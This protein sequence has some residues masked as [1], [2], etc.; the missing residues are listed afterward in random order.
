MSD[1]VLRMVNEQQTGRN[2][3]EPTVPRSALRFMLTLI[4]GRRLVY[5][6][7]CVLAG[8]LFTVSTIVGPLLVR[9]VIQ[10]IDDGTGSA[11]QLIP[12]VLLLVAMYLLRGLGRY[13]YGYLSHV[14]AYQVLHDLLAQT[15]EHVQTLSHKYL[16]RQRTGTLMARSISD[17]EMVEDFV[18]HGIPELTLAVVGPLVMTVIL[19]FIDPVV[20]LLALLPLPIASFIVYRKAKKIRLFW[21]QVRTGLAELIALVQDN[22]SG[23]TEI[24]LFNLE[25]FQAQRIHERSRRFRDAMVRAMGVS[26]IPSS[27][28]E[29]AGGL[30]FI[31]VAWSGGHR[32]LQGNLSV[33]DFVLFVS[34]ISHIYLPFMK[35]ADMGDSLSRAYVSLER[36]RETL[37]VQ[38]EIQSPEPGFDPSANNPELAWTV[39][40]R[41]VQFAYGAEGNALEGISFCVHPGQTVALVGPTGAGK[42][43]VGRLIPRLYDVEGGQILVAGT[44]VREWELEPLRRHVSFVLQE[45]FL[46]HGTIRENLL[47]GRPDASQNELNEAIRMAHATEF[48]DNMPDGLETLIGERGVRLSG[49]Q[50]QRISI[51]RALL[52]N[53]PILVLD[54]ATSNVD[55]LT[56]LAIQEALQTLIKGRTTLVIAHRLSTIRNAH[57]VLYMEEGRIRESG[58]FDQLVAQGGGFAVMAEAQSLLQTV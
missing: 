39:E 22:L 40:F 26:M 15:Y 9:R 55:V 56:E 41:D 16:N 45:V 3:S 18:A 10:F 57:K 35:I 53:A 6:L 51:A 47:L 19:L 8:G 28:V 21:R 11:G 49:G 5:I 54:E 34:Y 17:V 23:L 7:L 42:T 33:A 24:K 30:G 44:D 48:I 32:A 36:I 43:T 13:L 38:A 14:V 31:L 1:V 29:I 37:Q 58:T 50:R 46:F 20:T 52:K 12:I 25:Q 4:Q 2:S 27:V